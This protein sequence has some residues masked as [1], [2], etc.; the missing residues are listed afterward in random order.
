M[1]NLPGR[2]GNARASRA[3]LLPVCS[4]RSNF[5]SVRALMEQVEAGRR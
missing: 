4:Q 5:F 2:A 3:A 1:K